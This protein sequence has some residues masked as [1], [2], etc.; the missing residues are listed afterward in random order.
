MSW[1][2]IARCFWAFSVC[3][4]GKLHD[5]ALSLFKKEVSLKLLSLKASFKLEKKTSINILFV[6]GAPWASKSGN[7][8]I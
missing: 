7:L 2:E 4:G 8:S 5:H 3:I 6:A 1:R